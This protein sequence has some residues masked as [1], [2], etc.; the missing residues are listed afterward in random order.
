MLRSLKIGVCLLA[1]A[2]AMGGW[3]AAAAPQ[4]NPSEA[5]KTWRE[6]VDLI[7]TP[8]EKSQWKALKS[9][10]ERQAYM[11]EFW[12]RRDPT[13]GT[14]QNEFR[15]IYMQRLM[16]AE[17]VIEGQSGA[18]YKSGPGKVLI[19]YGRP[20]EQERRPPKGRGS[21]I[22]RPTGGGGG[23]GGGGENPPDIDFG[24]GGPTPGQLDLIWRYDSSN[25]YLQGIDE[26]RF[27][28]RNY[29]LRTK[30]EL[31]NDAF[32]ASIQPLLEAGAMGGE[33]G[34]A[35]SGAS[36]GAATAAPDIVALQQLIEQGIS[37]QD[38]SLEHEVEFFTAPEKNTFT[39]VAFE[40]GKGALTFGAKAPA[41]ATTEGGVAAGASVAAAGQEVAALK[42]FGVVLRTDDKG[43]KESA[44]SFSIPFTVSAAEG[45]EQETDTHSFGV[46]LVPGTYELAWGVMDRASGR[47]STFSDKL[48]VPAYGRSGLTL[49]SVVVARK[50]TP[51]TDQL[52]IDKVYRGIRL[53]SLLIDL[54]L[55]RAFTK[56]DTLQLLYFIMG[57]RPDPRTRRPKLE[58]THSILRAKDHQAVA[59]LPTQT[60]SYFA[61]GQP[62]PLSRMSQLTP[63]NDY[64]IEIHVKDLR[65]GKELTERMPF[66]VVSATGGR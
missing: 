66:K 64:E 43:N 33:L 57:G 27:S 18:G 12:E 20:K 42:T 29:S 52:E 6:Q 61:V 1:S 34:G 65:S 58:V 3:L 55:D 10:E 24:G 26:I 56:R 45:D 21:G 4:E 36:P 46:T 9:N 17:R 50:L 59:R 41:D 5:L 13:P 49:T 23:A 28:G 53:G 44:Y 2:V 31:S 30:V 39:V 7:M 8:Q 22:D 37:Q 15:D 32:L 40:V 63:G 16:A 54:D 62:I 25:P 51:Q 38:L 14:S 47:L 48:E 35:A 60:L 11:V 19:I